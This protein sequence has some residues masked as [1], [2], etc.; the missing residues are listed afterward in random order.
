LISSVSPQHSRRSGALV[1]LDQPEPARLGI[2]CDIAEEN[3]PSMDLVGEMLFQHLQRDHADRVSAARLA[4]TLRRRFTQ[5]RA[6]SQLFFNADRLLNRFWD[7]Q[8]WIRKR[9]QEFDLFHLIDHSYSQLLHHLP[10]GRTI[11]T[12]HDLDTFRSLIDPK[13]EPRSRLFKKM[14]SNVLSGFQKA[15]LVA[16]DSEATRDELLAHNLISPARLRVVALGVHPSC[17]PEPDATA[18]AEA[19]QYLKAGPGNSINLLHVGSTIKRK[20]IDVLLDTVA[21]VRREFPQARLI[22]V[23]GSFTDAQTDQVQRLNL[24][25]AIVV[26]P[27]ISREV[28]AAVYRQAD[29]VLQPSE[30]EGF[31]LPVVEAMACGA[32][33]IASDLPVLREV[34]GDA[35]TYAPVADVPA[36]TNSISGLLR[37]RNESPE[38]WAARKADGIAQAAKFSWAEYARKMVGL[39]EELLAD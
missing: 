6:D 31:G 23:G 20:R 35:A 5:V 13:A 16:C 37:E 22:R 34:G 24:E 38:K 29:L 3:W 1:T 8:R 19:R 12:C 36:W 26:L 18:D 15:A 33:V 11:V 17:T 2:L 28:L 32:P 14:M 9:K 10:P 21:A 4:P 39:Y 27:H 25:N 30:G 7:Y